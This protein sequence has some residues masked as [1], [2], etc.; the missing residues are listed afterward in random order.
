[1]AR[2]RSINV[3]VEPSVLNWAIESSGW[4]ADDVMKRLAISSGTFSGW[5]KGES[6]PTLNQLENLAST[7]KRP[8]AAFLLS[9]PPAEKPM[10]K[11]YRMISGKE[12]KFD[13]KSMLAIRRARR[14]QKIGKELSDNIN[15]STI[16]VLP[17]AAI[18][19][20]P[21]RWA[22]KYR[23][24]LDFSEERQKKGDSY[25]IFNLLRE[26]IE[27]RNILV[28]QISMPIED[29][30]GFTLADD[31]PAVIVIN[32]KDSIE[33]RIFTLMHEFGHILLQES[34][35]SMPEDALSIKNIDKV[36]KWC[37]DFSSAFLLP[38]GFARN[39]FNLHRSELIET[40]TLNNIS[41]T[42]KLSKA[43]LVYNMMKL[44]FISQ[45]QYESVFERYKPKKPE[46]KEKKARGFGASADRKC[47]SE[48]GQKFVSLVLSNVERGFITHS[49]ALN[50]LSIKSKNLDKVA[51]KAKK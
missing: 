10:P 22:E 41:K 11:D 12:G 13:K 33:A 28:F 20:D 26:I 32:S 45:L 16:S 3:R 4:A 5:L 17:K 1:M 44:K 18:D 42:Y 2:K 27:E 23:R 49:D 30:R 19:N 21:T 9:S 43:M 39:I 7:L 14:L 35:V 38:E 51:G 29:A 36:E 15:A 40:E 25:K 31:V 47:I 34:G 8:L 48:K 46:K 37:N 50:Y 6:S 24:E